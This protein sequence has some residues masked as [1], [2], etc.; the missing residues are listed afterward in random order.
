MSS[1]RISTDQLLEIVPLARQFVK[2]RQSLLDYLVVAIG[3]TCHVEECMRDIRTAIV[4]T[5]TDATSAM[6]QPALQLEINLK[7]AKHRH[8][9]NPLDEELRAHYL[10]LDAQVAV[11]RENKT[12]Q[13]AHKHRN[14]QLNGLTNADVVAAIEESGRRSPLDLSS[15]TE[16]TPADL[17][18]VD[19]IVSTLASGSPLGRLSPI[20]RAVADVLPAEHLISPPVAPIN[21]VEN[22]AQPPLVEKVPTAALLTRL[23]KFK[24]KNQNW[25]DNELKRQFIVS[26]KARLKMLNKKKRA[27]ANE[28]DTND[29]EDK[30]RRQL[31]TRTR[32]MTESLLWA[33]IYF[34]MFGPISNHWKFGMTQNVMSERARHYTPCEGPLHMVWRVRIMA[35]AN[36]KNVARML[37]GNIYL[38]SYFYIK[39]HTIHFNNFT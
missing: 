20:N 34:V 23:L 6:H 9:M 29:D 1:S 38:Q 8:L 36:S 7:E 19:P 11:A 15:V 16:Q 24:E 13:N 33:N 3:A 22:S 10:N 30:Q 14:R 21:S 26:E 18:S 5:N 37:E 12:L 17:A 28:D 35:G 25:D 4:L 27:R 39:H 2:N 31:T 32:I